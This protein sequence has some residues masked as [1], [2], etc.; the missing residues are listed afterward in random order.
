MTVSRLQVHFCQAV[1]YGV[2][3]LGLTGKNEHESIEFVQVPAT[4]HVEF[5]DSSNPQTLR[6]WSKTRGS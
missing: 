1:H 3:E 4:P 6:A 5:M 2:H